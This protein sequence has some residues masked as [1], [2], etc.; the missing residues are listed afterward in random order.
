MEQCY[1]GGFIDDLLGPYRTIATAADY[2]EP[3]YA[4]SDG[5]YNEFVYHWTAATE[6]SPHFCVQIQQ[7]KRSDVNRALDGSAL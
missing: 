3:S 6:G 5:L 4:R 2:D 1:S 7:D